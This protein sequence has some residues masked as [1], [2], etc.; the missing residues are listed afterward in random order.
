MFHRFGLSLLWRMRFFSE[1]CI[2]RSSNLFVKLSDNIHSYF[3]LILS[4]TLSLSTFLT[5]SYLEG[6]GVITVYYDDSRN[7]R[8]CNLCITAL[9]NIT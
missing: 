4:E 1:V 5:H 8:P 6:S 7:I 3:R 9:M 2:H